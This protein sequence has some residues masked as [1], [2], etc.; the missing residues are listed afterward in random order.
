MRLLGRAYPAPFDRSDDTCALH[1]LPLLPSL[2]RPHVIR[3]GPLVTLGGALRARGVVSRPAPCPRPVSPAAWPVGRGSIG[4]VP[5]G[6]MRPAVSAP[7]CLTGP[8]LPQATVPM[9]S[10]SL[11][12][13]CKPLEIGPLAATGL[14]SARRRPPQAMRQGHSSAALGAMRER[15]VKTHRESRKLARAVATATRLNYDPTCYRQM[16]PVAS[17]GGTCPPHPPH[18]LSK[19]SRP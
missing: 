13:R 15:R 11:Q 12:K 2:C 18:N 6:S 3:P 5:S 14:S 16:R 1:L 10:K 9:V 7:L 8:I 17:G 19:A 4:G